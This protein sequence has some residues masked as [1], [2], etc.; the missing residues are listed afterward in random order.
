MLSPFNPATANLHFPKPKS[1][2][3]YTSVSFSKIV[4]L[5]AIPRSAT[6]FSTYVTTSDGFTCIYIIL[7]S[8][9]LK[10]SFL[11]SVSILSP[12]FF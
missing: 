9:S 7:F 2:I 1:Y 4:S 5:P 6:P 3:S 10:I 12:R 11:V 8:S